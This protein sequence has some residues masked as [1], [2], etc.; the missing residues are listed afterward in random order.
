MD[1]LADVRVLWLADYW[2]GPKSG[3]AEWRGEQFWFRTA[4]DDWET[5]RPRRFLLLQISTT[6]L[7]SEHATHIAFEQLVGTHYCMHLEPAERGTREKST[8]PAF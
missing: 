5:E 3:L 8:W 7:E 2:D 6:D 1:T 4:S